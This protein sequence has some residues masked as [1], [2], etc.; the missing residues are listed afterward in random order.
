[1]ISLCNFFLLQG[2]PLWNQ[3]I[4]HLFSSQHTPDFGPPPPA[5]RAVSPA[6]PGW[7]SR[8]RNSHKVPNFGENGGK[9]ARNGR[10]CGAFWLFTSKFWRGKSNPAGFGLCF[11]GPSLQPVGPTPWDPPGGPANIC[12][13]GVLK[14][15]L[16]I[17]EFLIIIHLKPFLKPSFWGTLRLFKALFSE[18]SSRAIRIEPIFFILYVIQN[19]KSKRCFWVFIWMDNVPACQK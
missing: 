15:V 3:T 16:F 18:F 10:F 1:M 6:K 2:C 13:V 4:H 7:M 8:K 5:G 9:A 14:Q 11:C 19:Q 12:P 17:K